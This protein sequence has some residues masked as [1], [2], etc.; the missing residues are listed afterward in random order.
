MFLALYS[1][2]QDKQ[3]HGPEST[4]HVRIRLDETQS[5]IRSFREA[6]GLDPNF[7]AQS[8][9]VKPSLINEERARKTSWLGSNWPS[10][11][12]QTRETLGR[13]TNKRLDSQASLR[14]WKGHQME[15][16]RFTPNLLDLSPPEFEA[17]V[18]YLLT[19]M[20]LEFQR[21]TSND[22]GVD[23]IAADLSSEFG[24]K[25]LVQAKRYRHPVS[26]DSVRSLYGEVLHQGASKGILIT[27]STFGTSAHSF[28]INKPLELIDGGNLLYLLSEYAGIEASITTEPPR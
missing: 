16:S 14:A 6:L 8:F 22:S 15:S 21:G 19:K 27:T 7:L 18:V 2:D 4:Q 26:V 5:L 1:K 3:A 11:G 9:P 28:A 24:G 13:T 17:L 20:G 12:S 25:L 23:G 10:R